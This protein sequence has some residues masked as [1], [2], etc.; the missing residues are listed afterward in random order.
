MAHYLG[1]F[2][3][4]LAAAAILVFSVSLSYSFFVQIAP[5]HMPWFVWAALGLTE[6]GLVCWLAVFMMQE[7]HD[8]H[9]TLALI[10]IFVCLAAVLFT[11]SVELARLFGTTF[12]LASI[13]YYALIVL[14]A[15]HL[16]A[17]VIDFFISYFSRY[18]FHSGVLSN[19]SARA[20]Q[21]V[22]ADAT[23]E[24]IAQPKESTREYTAV[25]VGGVRPKKALPGSRSRWR[26]PAIFRAE[27]LGASRQMRSLSA[28]S[29]P[30][31]APGE[32]DIIESR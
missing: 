24:L 10:M 17:F 32:N 13:Y 7:H 20:V 23:P 25:R 21:V 30:G 6:I 18:A 2:F 11:D 31:S 3:K 8:A 16:L 19:K 28:T 29:A 22:E 4:Y 12:F 14:F 9:K 5:A 1:A 15:A 26:I 27:P